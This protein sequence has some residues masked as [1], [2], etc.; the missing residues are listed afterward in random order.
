MG[1]N[2]GDWQEDRDDDEVLSDEDE[3]AEEDALIKKI[4]V[5]K[6]PL[7]A[8]ELETVSYSTR[9]RDVYHDRWWTPDRPA[10]FVQLDRGLVPTKKGQQLFIQYGNRSD[11]FLVDN[12]GFCLD[13]GENPF[14]AFKFRVKIGSQLDS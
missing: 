2:S 13:Y 9:L 8:A 1:Y 10:Y 3:L 14:S 6:E 12:Y 4:L 11:D 5:K 7:S